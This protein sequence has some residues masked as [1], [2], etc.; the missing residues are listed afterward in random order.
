ML[1]FRLTLT[2]KILVS[3]TIIAALAVIVSLY[4]FI[5]A[6]MAANASHSIENTYLPSVNLSSKMSINSLTAVNNIFESVQHGGSDESMQLVN[7]NFID[8]NNDLKNMNELLNTGDNKELLPRVTSMYAEYDKAAKNYEELSKES[9]R[10]TKNINDNDKILNKSIDELIKAAEEV[11]VATERLILS[12]L[13][14]IEDTPRRIARLTALKNIIKDAAVIRD[15]FRDMTHTSDIS[16]LGEANKIIAQMKQLIS[17]T[18]SDIRQG[19]NREIFQIVLKSSENA[20]KN[21]DAIVNLSDEYNSIVKKR[22]EM[23]DILEDINVKMTAA[24]IDNIFS[25]ASDTSF[26][27]ASTRIVTVVLFLITII[28][29]VAILLVLDKLITKPIRNMV[30]L[31]DDLTKGDGDLTKR[32]RVNT[33]DEL[34]DLAKEINVFIENVQ[35]IIREVKSASDD[36]ASGNNQL[37]ATME[38]LSSNFDNQA[39]QVSD[40]AHNMDN[41]TQLSN[42]VYK[43][44]D[45][46]KNLLGDAAEHTHVGTQQLN[47]VKDKILMINKQT[48]T[49]SETINSLSKNSIQIGEILVVINDIADQTNL[50]ALNAAIEAAR[51]GEAGRGFAV[52]A[53][54]VRKLA[55]RTQKATSEIEGIITNFQK[56]SDVASLEMKKADEVVREGVRSVD[57]TI[58]DFSTIVNGVDIANNDI[59]NINKMVGEQN[60]AVQLINENTLVIASGIE[61]STVAVSQVATTVSHLQNRAEQLK[62]LV[63]KFKV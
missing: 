48:D 18:Y 57:E 41:I 8:L 44:L 28:V 11:Y 31:V 32:I 33:N 54:E 34:G 53:D 63:E 5:S 10:I 24:A 4:S 23:R 3:A 17:V 45:E 30:V 20:Y 1:K 12:E 16:R 29:S 46:S 58:D 21:I 50:L 51:A 52:V 15:I 2:M 47:S 25:I 35:D 19:R 55:E 36:V 38:E 40:I 39:V 61:E 22:R 62:S 49:L 27:M 60:S 26:L 42:K 37:A 7:K 6:N 9:I 59:E 14:N 56:E 13:G 43:D